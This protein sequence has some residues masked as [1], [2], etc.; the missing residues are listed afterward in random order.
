MSHPNG[1]VENVLAEQQAY[2]SRHPFPGLPFDGV[3]VKEFIFSLEKNE[4][5][6]A[7]SNIIKPEYK[8]IDAACG[9]GELTSFLALTSNAEVTGVDFS[10]ST[11]DWANNLK[12]QLGSPENLTFRHQDV[13][14]L[15]PNEF[16]K[17]DLALAMG[18]WTSIPN[19]KQAME[20]LVSVVKPGGKVVF[21]FFD[22]VGRLF[23]RLKRGLLQSAASGFDDRDF[24]A[25]STLLAQLEDQNEIKWHVNQLNENVLNYHTPQMALKMMQECGISISDCVPI[26]GKLGGRVQ[27]TIEI[28]REGYIPPYHFLGRLRSKSDGYFVLTGQVTG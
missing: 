2:F 16:G 3:G 14:L 18:L 27:E 8:V 4:L 25:R 9:T 20:K 28:D 11:L 13:F 12:K 26:M 6:K 10:Q 22:P 17:F 7:I 5:Y 1:T 24:L 21:G 19:E 23:M 15:D